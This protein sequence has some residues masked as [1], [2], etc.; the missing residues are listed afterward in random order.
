MLIYLLRHLATEHNISGRY[1]GRA[2]DVPVMSGNIK[3]FKEALVRSGAVKNLAHS[4]IYHSESLR[5]SETAGILADTA[6]GTVITRD[7]RLNEVNYGDFE[8][9]FPSQIKSLY[10]NE[11]KLWMEKPSTV[12]FPNGES[13]EEVQKRVVS[14]TLELTSKLAENKAIFLVSHVDVIKM[15]VCWILDIPIDKK[16]MFRID[17]GS[18][19]CIETTNEMYN[20]KKIK[21][22]Y[23]NV[24]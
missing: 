9:K 5:C 20:H 21:V 19:S 24:T 12:R 4:R 14:L 7:N 16:R 11:Y 17:N 22:R 1:M 2:L 23:L 18:V 6:L 8:G 10:P 13:F 3:S 15:L